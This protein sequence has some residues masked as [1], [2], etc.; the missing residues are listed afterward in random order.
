MARRPKRQVSCTSDCARVSVWRTK[1]EEDA[2]QRSPEAGSGGC[3]PRA[4]P[5]NRS[6]RP[7]RCRGAQRCPPVK[8]AAPDPALRRYSTR[9]SGV[10]MLP[11]IARPKSGGPLIQHVVATLGEQAEEPTPG[12][13][14]VGGRPAPGAAPVVGALPAWSS[15]A[16]LLRMTGHEL[17]AENEQRSG[18][19]TQRPTLSRS[20]DVLS[21]TTAVQ[22]L[23]PL[24]P[25]GHGPMAALSDLGG[26]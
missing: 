9:C 22:L 16:P 12:G 11:P 10:T 13:T 5:A 3:T 4:W 2:P 17:P 7:G 23:R 1:V 6:P 19:A 25:I 8:A 20:P 26:R 21:V 15:R 18:G 14:A 24:V